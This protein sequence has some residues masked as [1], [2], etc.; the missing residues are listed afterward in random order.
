MERQGGFYHSTEGTYVGL[1]SNN[2]QQMSLLIGKFISKRMSLG[3][4]LQTVD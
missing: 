2:N 1:F 4:F 3:E